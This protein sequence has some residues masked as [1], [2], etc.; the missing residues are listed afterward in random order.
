MNSYISSSRES[1][2]LIG[3][4]R[5][6][7]DFARRVLVAAR[8]KLRRRQLRNRVALAVTGLL[9]A[10]AIP[11]ATLVHTRRDDLASRE[12]SAIAKMRWQEPSADDALADEMAQNATPQSAGDYL[13]PNAAAL[14][15][16]ASAYSDASW[17]Y[18]P[19]WTSNR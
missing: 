10:A 19:T 3:E 15:G 9:L 17:Q 6:P 7:D 13:L 2:F 12:S 1:G 4:P 8:K 18:D 5:L 16:F 11:L 14:T